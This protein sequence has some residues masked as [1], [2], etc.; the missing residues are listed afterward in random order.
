VPLLAGRVPF[1]FA[2][3]RAVPVVPVEEALLVVPARAGAR[4]A[5]LWVAVLG[6]LLC[7]G[8]AITYLKFLVARSC[9]DL[10]RMK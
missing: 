10:R 1:V 4:V 2:P 7:F 5:L 6:R 9:A 8:F 3:L